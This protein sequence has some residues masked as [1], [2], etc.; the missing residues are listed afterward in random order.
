MELSSPPMPFRTAS[1]VLPFR[2]SDERLLYDSKLAVRGIEDSKMI[3]A[4]GTTKA[5]TS[6]ESQLTPTLARNIE[7]PLSFEARFLV[8]GTVWL[9][10]SNAGE[11]L[12]AAGESLQPAN[13]ATAPV[14][15]TFTLFVDSGMFAKPPWPPPHF[16]GLDQFVYAEYGSGASILMDLQRRRVIG[17]MCQAM[18]QDL[19]YW[20]TVLIPVLLGSACASL[21]ILPLHCAC[22]V[23]SGQ[24][25]VLAGGSGTGKST[26]AVLLCLNDFAY[27]ADG[28]T[29]FSRS[30]SQV[31][32][33]GLPAPVKLLPDALQY[34]PQL[35]SAKLDRA[36]NG[37]V[38]YEVDPVAT[39]GVNR[40][41]YCEP[42][43]LV[44]LERTVGPDAA[45][46]RISS[47]E[48]FS[49]LAP[50][51]ESLPECISHMRDLQ[52]HS[53]SRL[54][55]RECWVLGHGS[56]PALAAK[57][58]LELCGDERS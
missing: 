48:A 21:G 54:V 38:A 27:L 55:D 44:F 26:L 39:F 49:R 29:Y 9:I 11:I 1:D 4:G 43:W 19:H 17:V 30:G 8:A 53:I 40:A 23:R 47:D 37:E 36:L 15:L 52:L 51:L 12:E 6:D 45:L 42:R 13:D 57:Q 16:R 25:L 7:L 24:G 58:L 32:A 56:P 35:A 22:V 2:A 50:E 41:L 20:R 18:A 3:R 33:W 34:F 31:S 14:A 10:A 46:R 28:W 5:T